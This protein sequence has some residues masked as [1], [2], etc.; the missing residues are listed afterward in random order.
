VN[1]FSVL[2]ST[3]DKTQDKKKKSKKKREGREAI[4]RK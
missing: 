3:Q 4:G 1:S 2:H